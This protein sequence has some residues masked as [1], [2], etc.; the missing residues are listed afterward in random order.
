MAFAI[1]KE[2][3]V[4][5]YL[6]GHIHH[7]FGIVIV[8]VTLVGCSKHLD[9]R[10]DSRAVFKKDV[11]G[12]RLKE[13]HTLEQK[14]RET[15]DLPRGETKSELDTQR[16]NRVN[17]EQ[18]VSNEQLNRTFSENKDDMAQKLRAIPLKFEKAAL[19]IQ[20]AKEN[21]KL[22]SSK[23]KNFNSKMEKISLKVKNGRIKTKRFCE[24]IKKVNQKLADK[25]ESVARNTSYEATNE[26]VTEKKNHDTPDASVF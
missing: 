9:S 7:L 26:V 11:E 19:K 2:E 18:Y 6:G 25:R 13:N 23:L 17:N 14:N 4:R 24:K 1:K 3:R 20:K 10:N 22:I 16:E 5:T 8:A 15:I 21:S 12:Q